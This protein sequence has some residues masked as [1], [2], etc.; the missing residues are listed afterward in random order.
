M[1]LEPSRSAFFGAGPAWLFYGAG[2]A[3]LALLLWGLAR[4]RG[5]SPL[6]W[7]ARRWLLLGPLWPEAPLRAGLIAM[8]WWPLWLMALGSALWQAHM[9]LFPFLRGPA[10]LHFSWVMDWLGAV[11]TLACGLLFLLR[12]TFWRKR[13]GRVSLWAPLLGVVVGFS[14]FVVEAGRLGATR[15][16]WAWS[17]PAGMWLAEFWLGGASDAALHN[18]WWVHAGLSLL[19]LALLPWVRVRWPG[20]C[21]PA[22]RVAS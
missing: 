6:G 17:S 3:A 7:D 8:A 20:P 5:A 12:L 13:P 18:T 16:D 10:Y 11:F 22:R 15:P 21:A 19:A 9:W 14:G 1:N 4:R 2:A